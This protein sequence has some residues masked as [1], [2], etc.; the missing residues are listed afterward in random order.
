MKHGTATMARQVQTNQCG[1]LV[2]VT[3][4]NELK[5]LWGFATDLI[6]RSSSIALAEL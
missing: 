2:T 5:W 1:S 4:R 6:S 3:F